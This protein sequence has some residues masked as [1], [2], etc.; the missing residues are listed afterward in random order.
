MQER[1]IRDTAILLFLKNLQQLRILVS[2]DG[3]ESCLLRNAFIIFP[4]MCD[5]PDIVSALGVR[6]EWG[7]TARR[8]TSKGIP[9]NRI[10]N[11]LNTF[12]HDANIIS[13][14]ISVVQE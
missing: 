14:P 10:R 8:Q 6:R 5:H 9:F 7:S 2:R 3:H 4:N 13:V 11:A 12:G 1:C